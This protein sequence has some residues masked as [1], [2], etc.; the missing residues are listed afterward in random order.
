MNLDVRT[1]FFMCVLLSL[2]L[3]GLLALAGRQVEGI[4]GVREWAAGN[5]LVGLGLAFGLRLPIPDHWAL[6]F[7]STLVLFGEGLLYVGI[8]AF[9][10]KPADRRTPWALAAAALLQNLL[11][12]VV[13]PHPAARIALNSLL[14]LLI[15]ALC[16]KALLT[17]D[18]SPRDIAALFTGTVFALFAAGMAART[19]L[20]V[21]GPLDAVALY[22]G[23][24]GSSA[25]FVF[26]GLTQLC[27]AFGFVLMLHSRMAETLRKVASMDGLTGALTRRGLEDAAVRL[28]AQFSR[29]DACWAVM[30]LDIDHFKSVNDRHGHAAGDQVLRVFANVVRDAVRASDY[31]GRYGGEEFCILMPHS[32]E[33]DARLLAERL[34]LAFADTPILLAGGDILH[35]TVSIGVSASCLSGKAFGKLLNDADTALYHAKQ[36]GRNQV[37]GACS[38]LGAKGGLQACGEAG[39][40]ETLPGCKPAGKKR[41]ERETPGLTPG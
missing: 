13:M 2:M 25:T 20:A 1:L 9:Q 30:M 3:A 18:G 32:G 27:T 15:N 22:S 38:I 11:F 4:R 37:T 8:R 17:R 6:V 12:A 16:A 21:F 23:S 28:Q 29:I 36:H 26:V 31:F 40:E 35:C 24:M 34:R 14:T 41:P 10:D 5:L 19:L 7:G 39:G 33:D